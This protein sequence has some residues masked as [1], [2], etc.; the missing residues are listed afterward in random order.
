MH[1]LVIEDNPKLAVAIAHGLI[2]AGHTAR[3]HRTPRIIVLNHLL[4]DSE[5]LTLIPWLR[6]R[7]SLAKILVFSAL[8][9]INARVGGLNAGADNYWEKPY[10]MHGGSRRPLLY[11]HRGAAAERPENTLPSFRRALDLGA[12]A[13]EMDAHMTSDGHVV[14]SHDPTAERMCGVRAL[15]HESPLNRVRS[16]DAG[17]GFIDARGNRPFADQGYVIPTLRDIL[18]ELPA[19]PINIDLK[20]PKPPMIDRALQLIRD[21]D[22][23]GRVTLASLRLRTLL[24][25]RARRY[26]GPTALTRPEVA[27]LI[28]SPRRLFRALPMTGVT[29]Q[30]PTKVGP[31]TLAGPRIIAK[32]H[33]LGLRVDFWT[34]NDPDE[35]AQ[36]LELGAD[37]IM[38]DDPAAIAPVFARY[39]N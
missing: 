19:V 31:I 33:A 10:A 27:V 26:R 16:W 18:R 22:A 3:K 5:G 29:A 36:L 38:T 23:A 32:C 6:R 21:A 4:P 8:A 25:V 9:P 15:I 13:L 39:R 34:I 37:G 14:I 12:D 7:Y 2:G 24:A 30:I 1:I 20:Q 17:W 35:A 28:F 11:A